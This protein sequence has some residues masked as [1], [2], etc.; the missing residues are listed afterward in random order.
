[1][2][3]SE[4]SVEWW[5]QRAC[6]DQ[7]LSRVLGSEGSDSSAGM[8]GFETSARSSKLGHPAQGNESS[9]RLVDGQGLRLIDGHES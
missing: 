9:D 7:R 5:D 2:L 6:W 1:M 3:G 8:E 4:D